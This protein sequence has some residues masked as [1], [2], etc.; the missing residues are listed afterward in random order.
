[1]EP[2][3]WVWCLADEHAFQLLVEA[4]HAAAQPRDQCRQ[5]SEG[6]GDGLSLSG[7]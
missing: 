3:L 2:L 6:D 1:M 5:G 7:S 4:L